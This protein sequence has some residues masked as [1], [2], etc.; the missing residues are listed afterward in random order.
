MGE[1]GMGITSA[2]EIDMSIQ[3]KFTN[4]WAEI[5]QAFPYLWEM[6]ALIGQRSNANPTGIGN[7][8]S[9]IDVELL[10]R[11]KDNSPGPDLGDDGPVSPMEDRISWSPTPSL[12]H[13]SPLAKPIA[14]D[15]ED[16]LDLAAS[17]LCAPETRKRKAASV[18]DND[19]I[20]PKP[21]TKKTA[22]RSSTSTPA[23]KGQLS[24]KTKKLKMADQFSEVAVAEEATRRKAIDAQI[25]QTA[26]ATLKVKARLAARQEK[27][28][29]KSVEKGEKAKQK[30]ELMKL[31]L[32]QDHEL[33]LA[34]LRGRSDIGNEFCAGKQ[35]SPM[36]RR[37]S[38]S[39]TA[40]TNTHHS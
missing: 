31:K 5:V 7:G 24:K 38:H 16:M 20:V 9:E 6:K 8:Q 30:V 36:T 17:P 3:N 19:S 27:T 33:A 13:D 32:T 10:Q 39:P 29:A 40:S 4:K 23:V 1:T 34:Q 35:F 2:S 18:E 21:P 22:A 26:L 37:R 11:I 28:K 14:E 12:S 25:A 15:G